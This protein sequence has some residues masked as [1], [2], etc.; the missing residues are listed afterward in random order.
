MN[1][2]DR[3]DFDGEVTCTE[4]SANLTFDELIKWKKTYKME[5]ERFT[6]LV[7]KKEII[8]EDFRI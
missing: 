2:S 3:T 7:T 6:D 5:E 1:D 4:V 8:F